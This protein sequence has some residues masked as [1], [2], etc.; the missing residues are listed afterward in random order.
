MKFI[1]KLF[2]DEQTGWKAWLLDVSS[3]SSV[4][5]SGSSGFL[6]RII[7]D[8]L[9]TYRSITTVCV[10]NGAATS[11]WFDHWLPDGPLCSTHSALFSHTIVPNVSVQF[12][13]QNGF[14]LRLRP[15]LTNAASQQLDSLLSSLQDIHLDDG[16]DVRLLKLTGR[17]YTTR[18][19]Y[20]ALDTSGD[21]NDINGRRVWET[22]LPN[23]VKVF[24]WLYFKDRLSTKVNLHAKNVVD[25]DNCERCSRQPEDKEHVF[26]GCSDSASI[27]AT[28]HMAGVPHLTDNDAWSATTPAGLERK[29]WPFIFLTFL[30]RIWDGRN[31]HVFRGEKFC[32]RLIIS[33]VC[34]DLVNWRKRLPPE[35]VDG[36]LG[37]YA[38][39]RGCISNSSPR[40][41]F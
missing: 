23:K 29:L 32:S 10:R 17:P 21:A 4:T 33:R 16:P 22:K 40:L 5:D 24:A 36:L 25:T 31:G 27:W 28:I 7:N 15:R 8:E 30:W 9:N 19:A 3:P 1:D 34:D 20:A 35:H 41:E 14:D 11:F 37:W 18:D 38:H 13:F 26:F 12:V 39:L 6:W 2:G